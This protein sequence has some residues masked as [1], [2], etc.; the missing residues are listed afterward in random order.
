MNGLLPGF[1]ALW[2]VVNFLVSLGVITLL[3][4]LMF[5]FLPDAKIA[6][7]DVTIGAA[8]TA[9]LFTIGKSLIGLYLGNNSFSSTYGAAGSLIVILVWVYY[10]AQILFFGAEFTQVYARRYGSKIVPSEHAVPLTEAARAQQGIPRK[11]AIEE[12]EQQADRRSDRRRSR[13]IRR[14]SLLQSFLKDRK[15]RR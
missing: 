6:W 3:F 10:S 4:A 9:L 7:S 12:A 8:L 15:R 11:D 14:S 1:D 5:K 2:P 13:T